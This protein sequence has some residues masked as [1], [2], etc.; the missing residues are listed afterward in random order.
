MR[1]QRFTFAI[2]ASRSD[3]SGPTSFVSETASQEEAEK[4]GEHVSI[5]CLFSGVHA[6]EVGGFLTEQLVH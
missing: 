5:G 1:R 6:R 3:R 2:A 4:S